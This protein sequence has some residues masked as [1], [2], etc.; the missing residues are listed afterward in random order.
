MNFR[1]IRAIGLKDKN[2]SLKS[3]L[4]WSLGVDGLFFC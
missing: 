1:R 2:S 3:Q 4:S